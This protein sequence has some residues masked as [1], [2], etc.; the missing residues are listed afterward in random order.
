MPYFVCGI[1]RWT[2]E[3]HLAFIKGLELYG[4][5]WKK[6]AGLIKTRTVVQIRTHAQKYFL[7][8]SKA[9]QSGE[10]H[11]SKGVHRSGID[12]ARKRRPKKTDRP[13]SLCPALKQYFQKGVPGDSRGASPTIS[14]SSS[15][16]VVEGKQ[17][18]LAISNQSAPASGASAGAADVG[19]TLGDELLD[20]ESGLFNFLSPV[21]NSDDG[22]TTASDTQSVASGNS[23]SNSSVGASPPSW[24]A[25][26]AGLA[27][28]LKDAEGL[29]WRSDQGI[30]HNESV[31]SFTTTGTSSA[32]T[33]PGNEGWSRSG[34]GG[35]A[36]ANVNEFQPWNV[37]LQQQLYRD[38]A[39]TSVR[40][41]GQTA[42]A[43]TL[44]GSSSGEGPSLK[45]IKV[46]GRSA[47]PAMQQQAGPPSRVPTRSTN[48]DGSADSSAG[49]STQAELLSAP[50]LVRQC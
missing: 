8:L 24:Y 6:I 16:G 41:A 2:R 11:L 22:N 28:L 18:N 23:N 30:P 10:H 47:P 12:G 44:G 38:E 46:E 36:P 3:E 33:S 20:A 48:S 1:G 34:G 7:K 17:S 50:R 37:I 45:R 31:L 26:G 40:G 5:G 27:N 43:S 15:A 29:D 13:L 39:A 9:R 32:A 4:K 49:A 14:P 35:D 21:L 42:L 19:K 25:R